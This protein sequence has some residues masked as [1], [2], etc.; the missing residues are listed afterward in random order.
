MS[1]LQA[2]LVRLPVPL[3]HDLKTHSAATGVPMARLV[4]DAV[5]VLLRDRSARAGT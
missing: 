3:Y 4:A 5:R 1:S 2:F